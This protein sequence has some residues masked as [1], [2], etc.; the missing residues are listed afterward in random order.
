MI[1]A[2]I[3]LTTALTLFAT[4]FGVF[5][6]LVP[7]T[8]SAAQT[9][10]YKVNF[11]GRLTDNSGNILTDGLYNIKF[12]MFDA[13]SA[14]T[15]K[16]EEDRV[17]T[18]VDNR[19]QITNGLFNI[20]F[21]DLT[22][23]S[24]AL[25]SG[26]F[27]LYLEVE[28]PTPAT[29]TCATNG[30]AVFTEGAMTPRQPLAS[31]P[32][33]F[34]SDTLDG[35]DSTS[36]AQLATA[37]TYTAANL[38]TPGASAVVGLTVKA[39]TGGATNG[40]EVFDSSNVRQ[41]FFN[42]AG[43][44]NVGQVIQPTTNNAV[45]LGIAG[46]AFRSLFASGLDTGT[47]T[48]ALTIG[49]SNAATITIGKAGVGVGMPG[50]IT[51]SNGTINTGSG[52]ITTT[53]AIG[54]GA[55]T[56]TS[57]TAGAG[58]VTGGSYKIGANDINTGGGTP[59]LSNVDY[60][61]AAQ[62]I[63]GAKTLSGITTFSKV[64]GQGAVF[65]GSA[66]S[67][68]TQLQFAGAALSSGSANGTYIGS[69]PAAYTGDFLNFQVA[70]AVKLK[71]D[72]TG[73]TTLGGSLTIGS[74]TV[75]SIGAT[76]G[77][78]AG[79]TCGAN[80]AVTTATFTGGILTAGPGCATMNGTGA[81]TTL[82]NV[83]STSIGAALLPS[84]TFN[85][86][87]G[88][89]TNI[90]KNLYVSNID[91]QTTA[92]TA[93]TI[94]TAATT[95]GVTIGRPSGFAVN[96]P[97]GLT[98]NGGA[99]AT[100]NGAL[101]LGSGNITSTGTI[102]GGAITGTSLATSANGTIN[103]G[104]GTIGTTG[105]LNGGTVVATTSITSPSF[106]GTGAV[107]L[108]SAAASILT[109]TANASSTWSSTGVLTLTGSGVTIN[110]PSIAGASAAILIQG[111]NSTAGTAGNV[112]I[113]T[114]TTSTGLPAVNIGNTNAKAIQIGNNTSN[115]TVTIDSGTSLIAIGTGAQG[116]IIN[117]GT[118]TAAAQDINF[119]SAGLGDAAAGTLISLQ[120]GT[121]ASTAVTLGTNGAGGITID[122]GTTGSILIGNGANAKATTLGSTNTISTA[123]ILGGTTG[124]I[125]IGS[126]GASTLASTTNIANTTGNATQIVS[127]GA[128]A[129]GGAS[130]A[131][132][133]LTLEG[134]STATGIQIGNSAQAHGIQI[135]TAAALQTIVVGSNNTTS[136]LTLNGGNITTNPNASGII[137][138]G[139]FSTSDTNLVGLTLD[140]TATYTET[141][142]TCSNTANG[143]TIYYNSTSNSI[144]A[145]IRDGINSAGSWEDLVSTA[146]L[147][148][149]LYGVVPDSGLSADQGDWSDIGGATKG[150]CK[151]SWASATTVSVA[152][153]NAYSGGRKAVVASATVVTMPAMTTAPQWVHVCFNAAGT[154][155]ASLAGTEYQNIPSFNANN[156]ILCLADV[157]NSGVTANTIAKIYDYR[158]F[159][160]TQKEFVVNQT[161]AAGLGQV[162]SA[163]TSTP[164]SNG[165]T[166]MPTTTSTVNMR[167]VMLATTGVTSTTSINAIIAVRGPQWVKFAAVAGTLNYILQ[168]I[169]GGV[170][171]YPSS[172]IGA[173]AGV[174]GSLGQQMR[175]SDNT[176]CSSSAN[177]QMSVPTDLTIR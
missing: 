135:G 98:T 153:C 9:I 49:A 68:Q 66:A 40:L 80:Q 150:P 146:G 174:Y 48:T 117:V 13:A 46:T 70:S 31:S 130:A 89:A 126:V 61:D 102:G 41:A 36:F 94:G 76:P 177:C 167:G 160:T 63:S 73:N 93:L 163:A 105:A 91:A 158:T 17:M 82:N 29:A 27:P 38:F 161:T 109:I 7:Q 19:V 136:K 22:P 23:L 78:A 75:Y 44:L 55:I 20:Q 71:V 157:V 112:T 152:P 77:V 144:R 11:Q 101:T 145:C 175:L 88:A 113:D 87:L 64:G 115:P 34:N 33:A 143:G 58:T 84:A 116:R 120:G 57:L 118:T 138:S 30:C 65:S 79:V 74:G 162:V 5:A 164:V 95:T 92:N 111:G 132:N 169:T 60:L 12:R 45:D 151:V 67:G 134:G 140:S 125:N 26:A 97:G 69:N 141:A 106:T 28:L 43:S 156:P 99:I 39:S 137:I 35:L 127:I 110:T 139:G 129:A 155:V 166:Q 107:T 62:T 32:Y 123:N 172:V 72:N 124:S 128:N 6:L 81:T 173:S 85:Y 14:G 37:N 133:T 83:G 24:P 121:T 53:G 171:G 3:G 16:F 122:S 96:L 42:A 10:P 59:T 1:R 103:S 21:G 100:V 165:V 149:I 15:N 8:A 108:Q 47:V 90:W 86:D 104:S 25:F 51:T 148:A 170:A 159:S 168:P 147:G 176:T 154:V 56:G 18:G 142:S 2:F 119:G 52:S 131:N 54:G 114:G 50:G 4:C